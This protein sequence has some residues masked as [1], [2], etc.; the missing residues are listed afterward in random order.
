M[1]NKWDETVAH[2]VVEVVHEEGY[3][4]NDGFVA[5][6]LALLIFL[7]QVWPMLKLYII[8]K[9]LVVPIA[10]DQNILIW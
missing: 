2:I 1:M 3:E 10:L 6:R 4:I 5:S 8:D 9:A 7:G